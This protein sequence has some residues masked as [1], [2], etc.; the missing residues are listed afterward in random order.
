MV[1]EWG[2]PAGKLFPDDEHDGYSNVFRW[3]PSA[4]AAPP[5]TMTTTTCSS[6]RFTGLRLTP[7]VPRRTPAPFS[8]CS[9]CL[10]FRGMIRCDDRTYT[11]R[12]ARSSRLAG[13]VRNV[14]GAASWTNICYGKFSPSSLL[15]SL[16]FLSMFIIIS[17]FLSDY[18][19]FLSCNLSVRALVLTFSGISTHMSRYVKFFSFDLNIVNKI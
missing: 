12:P 6:Q 9:V 5:T 15:K 14:F 19:Y 16:D 7:T 13:E 18:L 10:V 3:I 8:A 11:L 4:K 17:L 2:A 1:F